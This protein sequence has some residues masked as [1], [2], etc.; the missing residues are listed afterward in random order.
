VDARLIA[1]LRKQTRDVDPC[2][3]EDLQ[4][5]LEKLLNG[6]ALPLAGFIEVNFDEKV[7]PD[8][9]QAIAYANIDGTYCRLLFLYPEDSET[10][11]GGEIGK[12]MYFMAKHNGHRIN[13]EI[14]EEDFEA[15]DD[16]DHDPEA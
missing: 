7:V 1:I 13:M 10:V 9:K 3:K 16:Y 15:G 12:H 14:G 11:S 6:F 2:D 8:W 4:Q 5:H